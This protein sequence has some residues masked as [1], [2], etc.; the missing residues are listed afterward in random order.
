MWHEHANA[1]PVARAPIPAPSGA[2]LRV[3]P[4][5]GSSRCSPRSP[6]EVDRAVQRPPTRPAVRTKFQVVALLVREERARVMADAS[7]E[8]VAARRAAQAARRGGDACWPGPPPGTRRCS[9]LLAED[10][11]V[12]DAARAYK[13]T[14][15][16]AGGLEPPE[17]PAPVEQAGAGA[18]RRDPGGAAVGHLA[19]AGEPVPGPGLRGRGPADRHAGPP[20]GRLGA[21]RPA[22]QLLRARGHR[23]ARLHDAAR[24]PPGAHSRRPRADAAPGPGRHGDGPRAPHVPAR[25]RARAR[26]DRPGA[27][28]RPGGRR[29]PAAG[30]RAQRGQDELGARGGAVDAVPPAHGGPRRRRP[31]G[32]VR[33]RRDRELRAPGPARRL[34]RRPRL[35]RHGRRRGAL[36]QEQVLPALAAR[37]GALRADPRA[38]RPAAADGADR[39]PADQRHRG[40]PGDLAVPRLDRRHEAARTR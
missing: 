9:Q 4:S 23:C 14:L 8:R 5:R 31:D 28:R 34:A 40:L 22:L 33:G 10:A 3:P 37:P 7:P 19:P 38:R 6:G 36:H 25:R 11:R 18:H 32:R 35:P 24:A 13:A 29:L 1:G 17:E 39:H 30:R 21:A 26:Q 2:S 16:R 12:S 27:A 20:A 15:M